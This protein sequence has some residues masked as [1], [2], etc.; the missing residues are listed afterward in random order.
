MNAATE[1]ND[2]LQGA[3]APPEQ[4]WKKGDGAARLRI[5]GGAAA[6]RTTSL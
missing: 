3:E 4:L 2:C 5:G 6:C 1:C